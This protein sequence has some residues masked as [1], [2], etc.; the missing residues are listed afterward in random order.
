[1]RPV[2]ARKP[3]GP[4]GGGEALA[5]QRTGDAGGAGDR[6]DRSARRELLQL[7]DPLL[8][9]GERLASHG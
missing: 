3:T 6:V 2:V 4:Q 1:M 7:P 5:L 9:C 8:T